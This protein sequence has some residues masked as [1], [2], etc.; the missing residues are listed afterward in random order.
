MNVTD[1]TARCVSCEACSA[2][3]HAAVYYIYTSWV[4]MP[5]LVALDQ[6]VWA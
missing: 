4:T 3:K 6:P 1:T 2:V 5:I